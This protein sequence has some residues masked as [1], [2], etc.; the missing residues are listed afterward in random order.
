[1]RRLRA[2]FLRLAPSLFAR[3][4][5]LDDRELGEWGEEIAARYL[6]RRGCRILGRRLRTEFVEIDILALERRAIV[7]VE[8]KTGRLEPLPRPRGRPDAVTRAELRWRPGRRCDAARIA[9]LWRAAR[10]L[11]AEWIG[12]ASAP[13]PQA[14]PVPRDGQSWRG[15][16][17]ARGDALP[18]RELTQE[19]SSARGSRA[20]AHVDLIEVVLPTATRRP[21]VAHHTDVT[22]PLP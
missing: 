15:H 13:R 16:A 14:D 3:W 12:P 8:V 10:A 9:R 2:C 7:C 4:C 6:R 11:Q 20:S 18:R 17:A 22:R 1:M 21:R 5:T 19:D